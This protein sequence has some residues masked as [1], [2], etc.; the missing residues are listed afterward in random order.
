[1]NRH[2]ASVHDGKKPYK[3]NLCEKSYLY[4]SDLKAHVRKIHEQLPLFI[5]PNFLPDIKSEDE[6]EN[7]IDNLVKADAITTYQIK[8]GGLYNVNDNLGVFLNA[9]LVEK[10]PI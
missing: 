8:G 2:L 10:A 4:N 7:E 5:D 6:D 3:C 1:M 9:C